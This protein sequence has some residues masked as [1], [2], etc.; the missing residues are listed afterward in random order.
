M[1]SDVNHWKTLDP[2][3]PAEDRPAQNL[4]FIRGTPGECPCLLDAYPPIQSV[5]WYRNGKAIR[6]ESKGE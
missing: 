4:T 6:I 5:S 2:P 1:L 3:L